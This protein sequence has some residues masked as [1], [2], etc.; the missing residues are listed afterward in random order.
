MN[1]VRADRDSGFGGIFREERR[2][3]PAEPPGSGRPLTDSPSHVQHFGAANEARFLP[4]HTHVRDGSESLLPTSTGRQQQQHAEYDDRA[5]NEHRRRYS[6]SARPHTTSAPVQRS[7]VLGSRAGGGEHYAAQASGDITGQ[8]APTHDTR[9]HSDD[10]HTTWRPT[11]SLQRQHSLQRS[12]DQPRRPQ[13]ATLSRH[14][15]D[16]RNKED[17]RSGLRVMS[18]ESDEEDGVSRHG[19]DRAPSALPVRRASS[20]RLAQ[21]SGRM[22]RTKIVTIR[23]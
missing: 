7:P 17:R 2:Q 12:A 5:E 9:H 4:E 13:T 14:N 11:R 21:E 23:T 19:H 18:H 10:D 8:R 16:D 22:G 20:A 1:N 15:Y 3:I 6:S